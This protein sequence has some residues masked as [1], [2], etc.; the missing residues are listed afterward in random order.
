MIRELKIVAMVESLIFSHPHCSF[1]SSRHVV[2]S[3]LMIYSNMD[4]LFYF[5]FKLVSC[6][7]NEYILTV[8]NK[9]KNFFL[10]YFFFLISLTKTAREEFLL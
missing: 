1:V 3:T 2:M 5:V 9:V 8:L 7:P 10:I 6:Y 4:L